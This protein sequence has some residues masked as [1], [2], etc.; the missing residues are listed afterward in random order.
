MDVFSIVWLVA[1]IIFLIIEALSVQLISIW[2]AGGA[3]IAMVLALLNVNFWIQAL[4]F[5][6]VS[7]VLIILTRPL[8][9]RILNKKIEATN[10]DR[11]IGKEASVTSEINNVLGKGQ[12]NLSGQIWSARSSD[13]SVINVGETVIVEKIDGVKLIVSRKQTF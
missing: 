2:L 6:V 7:L 9:K 10:A 3:I 11:S 5:A 8:V 12:V 4:I 13:D 1:A